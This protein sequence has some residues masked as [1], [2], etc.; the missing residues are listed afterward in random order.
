MRATISRSYEIQCAHRLPLVPAGHK[1]S[2]LHGHTYR[3]VVEVEG[4]VDP[5]LGWFLDFAELD[6]AWVPVFS[7]LDHRLLNEIIE[8]PTTENLARWIG[9]RVAAVLPEALGVCIRVAENSR[10][11]VRYAARGVR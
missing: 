8:N 5:A 4:D 10:S 3:V 7:V 1:C 11:E 9:E 6:A 2:R